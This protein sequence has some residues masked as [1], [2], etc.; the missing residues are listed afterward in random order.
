MKISGFVV[1]LEHVG[2]GVGWPAHPTACL[3]YTAD[4]ADDL[5]RV[6]LDADLARYIIRIP[7]TGIDL[8]IVRCTVR[9]AQS[10]E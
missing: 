10:L 8:Y 3:L 5:T 6:S 2:G 7:N 9:I 4:A 1:D